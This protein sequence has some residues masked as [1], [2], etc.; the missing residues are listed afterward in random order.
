MEVEGTGIFEFGV[1]QHRKSRKF[2]RM[3][4]FKQ[5]RF[6]GKFHKRFKKRSKF[7]KEL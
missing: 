5:T 2:R 4:I 6:N 1:K 3:R 7:G